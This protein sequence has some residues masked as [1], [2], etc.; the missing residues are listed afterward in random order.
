MSKPCV[1]STFGASCAAAPGASPNARK[2]SLLVETWLVRTVA[3]SVSLSTCDK[4]IAI[5][6][7]VDDGREPRVGT[8]ISRWSLG[9]RR[10]ATDQATLIPPGYLALRDPFRPNQNASPCNT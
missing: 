3:G 1:A 10:F 7:S 9:E 8:L 4:R 2:I 6:Y 5:L